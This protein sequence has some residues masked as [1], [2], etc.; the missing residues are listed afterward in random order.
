MGPPQGG[1]G[2]QRPGLPCAGRQREQDISLVYRQMG[3]KG[4]ES[5]PNVGPDLAAVVERLLKVWMSE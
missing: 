1:V 3:R 2:A 4:L 5:I